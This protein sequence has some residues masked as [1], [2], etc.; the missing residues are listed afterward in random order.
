MTPPKVN[1]PPKVGDKV[2]LQHG[3][4][5]N[6]AHHV[7]AIVDVEH[8]DVGVAEYHVVL[9]WW[10]PSKGWRY[11]V[12]SAYAFGYDNVPG[13]YGKKKRARNTRPVSNA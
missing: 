9:R 10:S 5:T 3:I 1:P 13:L 4:D 6:I 8:D 11:A 7:R 2:Y 12:E